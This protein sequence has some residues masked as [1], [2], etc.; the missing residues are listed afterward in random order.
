MP[1]PH[2]TLTATVHLIVGQL[3]AAGLLGPGDADRSDRGAVSLEQA[4]WYAAAAVAVAV[5]AGIIWSQIR[6][7]A[8][9]PVDVPTAP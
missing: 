8:A 6:T 7:T 1:D 3:R 9:T 4:L 5:V 2:L